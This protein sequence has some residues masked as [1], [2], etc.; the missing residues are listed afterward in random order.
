MRIRQRIKRFLPVLL[1]CVLVC[2][3]MTGCGNENKPDSTNGGTA[4]IP[5]DTVI[6]TKYGDLHYPDQWK[7]YVNIR[8]E[9]NGGVVTVTFET[10]LGG[11]TYTLFKVLLGGSEG[12][13]VG[14]LTDGSG[15]KTDVYLQVEGLADGSGLTESEQNRF[16]AMQ[17]DLNYLI[18]NLE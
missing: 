8:Q 9:E 4:E 18:D 1:C 3:V 16:Y 7:E 5:E 13:N 10:S 2:M 17:E 14:T 6:S 12:T 15:S 11:K